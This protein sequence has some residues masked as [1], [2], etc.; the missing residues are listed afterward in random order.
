MI[1]SKAIPPFKDIQ[2]STTT[3]M[4][5]TNIHF[6]RKNI[7]PNISI[8]KIDVPLRKKTKKIDK[9]SLEAP[10]GAVLSVQQSDLFRGLHTCG[11]KRWCKANCQL[12][13]TKPS[14]ADVKVHTVVEDPWPVRN[15]DIS[16]CRYY[17]T[18][19]ENYF[20]FS[21]LGIIPHFLN[22]ITIIMALKRSMPNIMLFDDKIKIVGCKK[23]DEA[24]EAVTTLWYE[25]IMPIS[26]SWTYIVNPYMIS[27]RQKPHFMFDQVMK[28]GKFCFDFPIDREKVKNLMSKQKYKQDVD[29]AIFENTKMTCARVKM[30]TRLPQNF[31]YRCLVLPR[32]RKPYTIFVN[33]IPYFRKKTKGDPRVNTFIIFSSSQTILS[34]R[35]D[36]DMDRVYRFFCQEIIDHRNEIEE[37]INKPK[38]NLFDQAKKQGINLFPLEK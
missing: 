38:K 1:T 9:K 37:K 30:Y 27:P 14:G 20:T 31:K 8:A 4:V 7:F 21:Q 28:N 17:C 25:H 13:R 24:I 5:Y 10:Y 29:S 35:Y 16:M 32:N 22:Q 26:N 23:I 12:Y 15:T 6:N 33:D 36:E 3:V 11:K 34:G 2:V 19:C 18:N